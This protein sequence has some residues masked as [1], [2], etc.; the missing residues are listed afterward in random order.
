[1]RLDLD[2]GASDL[3]YPSS[4]GIPLPTRLATTAA[5]DTSYG[6]V[7]NLS[8]LRYEGEI[9]TSTGLRVNDVVWKYDVTSHSMRAFQTQFTTAGPGGVTE[10]LEAATTWKAT[11]GGN[12][13]HSLV[14]TAVGW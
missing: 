14:F 12:M 2:N 1:V 7:R 11:L 10:I 8:Y 6:M 13:I 3:V 5:G 9:F 4:G